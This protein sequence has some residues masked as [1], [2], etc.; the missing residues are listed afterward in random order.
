[1]VRWYPRDLI[2]IL[3]KR[4]PPEKTHSLVIMTKFPEA[5]LEVPLAP[6]LSRYE[7]IVVHL[8]VT[9]LGGTTL[10]PRV[11]P[12]E[13]AL[14][15]L[16]DIV[17][18]VGRP[19]RVT[20]RI[21]PIVHWRE[22]PGG[23]VHTNLPLFGDIARKAR[24]WGV[25]LVKSSLVTPYAKAVRRFAR[26]GLELVTPTGRLRQEVLREMEAQAAAAGLK[27]EFCC[28]L[29]RESSSCIDARLLTDLH[30]RRLPAREDRPKGQR[31]ACGCTHAVDLA[32]YSTHPCPSGCLYCYANPTERAPEA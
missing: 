5:L 26:T 29:T 19:E 13:R 25:R 30:P 21:D 2:R 32:W 14:A 27:L 12:P 9:G 4:Y 16:A 8:T 7:Q 15:R 18:F 11:P 3:E 22:R 10:E 1:M 28:E 23:P 24:E 31:K 6:V 17:R 20:L